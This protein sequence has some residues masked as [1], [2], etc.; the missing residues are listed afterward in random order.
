VEG[1]AAGHGGTWIEAFG[2]GLAAV[3]AGAMTL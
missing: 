2:E 3:M 1:S